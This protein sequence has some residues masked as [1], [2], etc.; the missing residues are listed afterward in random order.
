MRTLGDFAPLK[1][2]S[3]DE[4]FLDPASV[5]SDRTGF[6]REIRKTVTRF[7]GIPISIGVAVTKTLAKIANKLAKK[8]PSLGGVLDVTEVGADIDAALEA[9]DVADVWGVGFANGPRLRQL[10]ITNASR[11]RD[12][13]LGWI[14]ARMTIVGLRTVMKLRGVSCIELERVA[15]TRKGV[16]ASRSFGS[17]VT[18]LAVVEEAVATFVTRAEVRMR[19]AKLATRRLTVFVETNRFATRDRQYSNSCNVR[20]SAESDDTPE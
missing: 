6:C 7:T 20:L 5:A 13:D 12:V 10:G 15:P 9:T 4:A 1:V 14:R 11:L 19:R 18:T 8:T 17:A 16:T 3:I 2:Y